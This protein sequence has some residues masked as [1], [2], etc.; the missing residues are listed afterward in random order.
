MEKS[1]K[2]FSSIFGPIGMKGKQVQGLKWDEIKDSDFT[3]YKKDDEKAQKKLLAFLRSFLYKDMHADFIVCEPDTKN[4]VYFI[5]GYGDMKGKKHEVL[6]LYGFKNTKAWETP[7]VKSIKGTRK[8]GYAD[9]NLTP[10]EVYE[11]IKDYDT[12]VLNITDD[13]ISSY[14]T[15]SAERKEAQDGVIYYDRASLAQMLRRQKARYA[16]AVKEMKRTALADNPM[17]LW[18]QMKDINQ[19]VVELYE[20]IISDP[21]EM[22]K[23]SSLGDLMSYVY[24]SF[25]DF[26]SFG[27]YTGD[28]L[29][30]M[31][32]RIDQKG[33]NPSKMGEWNTQLGQ[34]CLERAAN[35]I[36]NL[37]KMIDEIKEK[38]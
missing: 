21:E 35:R 30:S 9:K 20:K 11:Y 14:K 16:T 37:R 12:Y 8:G 33:P 38:M 36:K 34:E 22:S 4:I 2:S 27:K 26:L 19:E 31:K 5:K 3:L 24:N 6:D 7:G 17:K 13:M 10:P 18:N 15:L 1:A 25:N 29:K 32:T 28:A 23:Y